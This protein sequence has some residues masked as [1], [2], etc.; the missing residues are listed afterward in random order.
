MTARAYAHPAPEYSPV[1]YRRMGIVQQGEALRCL[2]G[3]RIRDP[4]ILD[5]GG[6]RCTHKARDGTADCGM[7]LYIVGGTIHS[8]HG[9]PI[10]VVAEVTAQELQHMT[11]ERMDW[12]AALTYLGVYVGGETRSENDRKPN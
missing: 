9:R 3:H 12:H 4:L 11:R 6:V 8:P 7:L 5:H 2:E 1:R 10:Y